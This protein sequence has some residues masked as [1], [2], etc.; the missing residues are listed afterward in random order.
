MT[1]STPRPPHRLERLQASMG[2]AR[3][4]CT[5]VFGADNVNHLC[6]YWRY[7]GGPSALVVGRDGERTLVVMLD[8]VPI[9][10][11]LSDAD[12]VLGYGKRGFGF[13]L[14]PIAGLVHTVAAVP[15][16]A[17]A[18]RIGVSSELPGADARLGAAISASLSDAGSALHRIR[19]IKDWDEL[20]KIGAGYELCWLGQEAVA[21]GAVPGASE[22]ELFTAAQSTAQIA[23]GGPIE[24]ICD[25]LSGTSTADV[26][27][28]V[29][30]AGPRRLEP[31]DPVVADV[32][33]R[34]AGYW[35]DSAGTYVAGSNADAAA[36]R[37]LLLDV[38]EQTRT[39][40]VPGATGAEVF[41]RMHA[42]ITEAIPEGELPHHAGHALGLTSFEDPHLI[43]SD[44][45]PFEPWMVLAVEPG[46][47]VESR[48]GARVENIFVVMPGGGVELRAALGSDRK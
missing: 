8:E 31:G 25:L 36:A 15:A 40:L 11:R 41:E 7:F 32:V 6:G 16:V 34:T 39:E 13:D 19:L 48:Y 30:V 18:D 37:T 38:L 4:D 12:R 45:M 24:F 27:C 14:D 17:R 26:C 20:E 42:R 35:G 1:I 43:P 5:V 10:E 44:T 23:S 3:I 9:A 21:S 2:D 46:V 29:H 22:I 33:V 28:P 47:Y